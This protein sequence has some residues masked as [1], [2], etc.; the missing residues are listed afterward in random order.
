MGKFCW[1]EEDKARGSE[2]QGQVLSRPEWELF[3]HSFHDSSH[4]YKPGQWAQLKSQ[5]KYKRHS[6]LRKKEKIYMNM[7][8]TADDRR[9]SV[10]MSANIYNDIDTKFLVCEIEIR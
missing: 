3:L 1:Q 7:W 4:L 6:T 2:K 8:Q 10:S 5:N 9:N